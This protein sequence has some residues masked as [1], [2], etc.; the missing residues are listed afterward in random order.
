MPQSS[1]ER[2]LVRELN[3][4]ENHNFMSILNTMSKENKAW[5]YILN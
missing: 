5:K 1:S 2:G 3:Y 4:N